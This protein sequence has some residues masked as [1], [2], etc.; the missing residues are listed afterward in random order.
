MGIEKHLEE[1]KKAW[2]LARELRNTL[3]NLNVSYGG[4]EADKIMIKITE[5]MKNLI[6]KDWCKKSGFRFRIAEVIVKE[7]QKREIYG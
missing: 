1:L 2:Y 6:F 4:I 3:N 5:S 7:T